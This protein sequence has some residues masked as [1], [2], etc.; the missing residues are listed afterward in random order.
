[1]E[2]LIPSQCLPTTILNKPKHPMSVALKVAAQMNSQLGGETWA[3][4]IQIENTM[5]IGYDNYHNSVKKYCIMG[6]VVVSMNKTLTRYLS[7]ANLHTIPSQE[8]NDDM[9]P[10]ITLALKKY[11]KIKGCLVAKNMLY[12]DGVGDSVTLWNMRVRLWRSSSKTLDLMEI[13]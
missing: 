13:K 8:I 12:R 2:K 1:M 4:Q 9:C 7:V 11:L 6:A 10:V 3:S 5:M